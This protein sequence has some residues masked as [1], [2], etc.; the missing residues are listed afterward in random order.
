MF[1]T[2]YSPGAYRGKSALYPSQLGNDDIRWEST[3]Q[4]DLGLDFSFLKNRIGGT[5]AFYHKVTDGALLSVTPAPSSGFNSVISN[6]AKIR[7]TGVEFELYGDFIRSKNFTWK[8]ALNISHNGSKVLNIMDSDLIDYNDATGKT[9]NMGT[10]ILREGEPLGLL[11]GT[12]TNGLITT[13]EQLEAYKGKYGMW[14]SMVPDM[15]IGSPEFQVADDGYGAR[16]DII[17]NC[18]PDFYGGYTNT[19]TYKNWSLMASFTFSYGNDLIYQ[20]DTSDM[21]FSTLSNRGVSVLD[22]SS[23]NRLT[24]RPLS[25]Y[26]S[27]YFMTDMNVYD[28]SY[29]KLQT[30]SLSYNLPQTVLRK[31]AVANAQVY[32]T[33]SNLFT[34]TSY[35]GPDPSVSDNP[36]TISGGGRDISSYP[37]VRS[38]TFGL[39]IGF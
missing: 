18:T 38:F 14:T 28:A 21:T 22:A 8:G 3:T 2:L 37:T 15:G 7:N 9:I 1:L 20:K 29:L 16:N 5:L 34:I 19:F 4:K 32:V 10:S 6:I 31:L 11:Y 24:S 33:A 39:R 35:P 13:Q 17:G 25:T 27:V 30:L 26:K 36:Y 23:Y 12:K